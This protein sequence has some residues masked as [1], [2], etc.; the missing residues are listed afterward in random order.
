MDSEKNIE[1][2]EKNLFD[3][4]KIDYPKSKDEVWK[5]METLLTESP[6]ES[7]VRKHE[8][9]IINMRFMQMSAAAALAL[10]IVLTLFARFYSVSHRVDAGAFASHVLIDG[11]EIHLNAESSISYSPYWWRFDRNVELAGEAFFEVEKGK[12]FSVISKQGTTT[13]LG[14][15]FNIYARGEDY[16]VY[17]VTGKV[18]VMDNRHGGVILTPGEFAGA[19]INQ[20]VKKTQDQPENVVLAW[21]LNKFAYNTT[22]LTKVFTDVARHYDITIDM[23]LNEI[24]DYNYTGL[25]ERSVSA[26]EALQIICYSFD[27]EYAISG[28]RSYH[29]KENGS[30]N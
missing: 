26:E 1:Q 24:N 22:P 14:T 17:C 8:G 28:P 19:I 4:V 20:N 6:S 27:L 7:S 29:V 25:F 12:A 16:Q 3:Q 30:Q 9:R 11:S 23:D 10:L 13:V 5:S 15:S 2:Q 18:Q 21:R